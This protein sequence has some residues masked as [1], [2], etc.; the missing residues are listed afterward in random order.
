MIRLVLLVVA[1]CSSSPRPASWLD[2][3]R[4]PA[5]DPGIPIRVLSWPSRPPLECY[6]ADLPAIPEDLE[7]P[8]AAMVTEDVF[9]RSFVRWRQHNAL[10]AAFRD[11]HH[12][13]GTVH[14]CIET[15]K[16]IEDR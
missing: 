15:L 13:A 8:G 3:V 5:P 11:L 7:D 12:W 14:G 6:L 1:A 9:M 4:A 16:K 2:W 10:L